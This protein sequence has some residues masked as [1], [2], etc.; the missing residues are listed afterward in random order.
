[1]LF[2]VPDVVALS[3]LRCN[4]SLC[5]RVGLAGLE[6]WSALDCAAGALTSCDLCH[7]VA[8]SWNLYGSETDKC[9]HDGFPLVVVGRIAAHAPGRRMS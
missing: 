6:A 3:R 4:L 5:K 9:F 7:R 8:F 2:T 1:M